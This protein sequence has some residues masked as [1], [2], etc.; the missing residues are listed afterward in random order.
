M[1]GASQLWGKVGRAF[2]RPISERQYLRYPS[3]S[4]FE[5]DDALRISLQRW[6]GLIKEGPPR[7]IDFKVEKRSDV[8][9][10]A[11]GFTSDPRDRFKEPDRVGAVIFDP[12][13][14]APTQFSEVIPEAIQ[15]KWLPRNTQ[16]V[17]IEMVAPILALMTF[18]DR[19]LNTDL[20]LLID[21]ESVEASL[22]KGYSSREDLCD[23]ISAF[24]NLITE[25]KVRVFIDRVSTDANPADW[26]SRGDLSR[27][28]QAGWK[29]VQA[30]WPKILSNA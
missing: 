3:K 24:W 17:P 8:V 26:P 27:G 1:F 20:L 28:R 16:I 19:L 25:L 12:K 7:S 14:G 18:R 10:F 22:V 15:A 29:T 6:R 4:L 11:N 5:L 21:S 13:L 30:V 2:L 23:L 9:I